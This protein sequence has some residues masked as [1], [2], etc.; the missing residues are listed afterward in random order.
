MCI[1]D[2]PYGH[3]RI[4]YLAGLAVSVMILVIGV[5]LARSSIGKILSPTAVEFSLVTCLLYTSLAW[6]GVQQFVQ[7]TVQHAGNGC[8]RLPGGVL[9]CLLYTSRCV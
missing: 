8:D 7:R 3:A 5:E 4:E 9:I 6:M 2:S 1:R